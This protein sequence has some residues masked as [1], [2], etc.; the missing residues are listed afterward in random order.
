MRPKAQLGCNA[1]S[2]PS[3][4]KLAKKEVLKVIPIAV[5]LDQKVIM[6]GHISKFQ[7][8]LYLWLDRPRKNSKQHDASS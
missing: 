2:V 8:K 4:S 1:K 3:C 5:S 6:S 7:G